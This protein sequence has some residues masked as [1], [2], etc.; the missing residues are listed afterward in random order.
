MESKKETLESE[1][2]EIEKHPL[3]SIR[4]KCSTETILSKI[5]ITTARLK[6]IKT[7]LFT[8]PDNP[9]YLSSDLLVREKEEIAKIKKSWQLSLD[10]LKDEKI[11][12]NQNE[13]K[14]DK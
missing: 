10:L 13:K 4:P 1:E 5:K 2:S 7:Y 6:Q 9:S 3:F 14:C 8:E 12:I 11:A